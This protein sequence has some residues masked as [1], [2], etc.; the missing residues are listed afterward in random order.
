MR[1]TLKTKLL[2]KYSQKEP[3]QFIQL[4]GFAGIPDWNEDWPNFCLSLENREFDED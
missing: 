3:Q 2:E 4:D 1:K